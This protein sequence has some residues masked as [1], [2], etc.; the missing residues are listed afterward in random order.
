MNACVSHFSAPLH[1]LCNA[2][3]HFLLSHRQRCQLTV[4]VSTYICRIHPY[5]SPPP[6]FPSRKARYVYPCA[7][8]KHLD[9]SSWLDNFEWAVITH[10]AYGTHTALHVQVYLPRVILC[11]M[12]SP[13]CQVSFAGIFPNSLHISYVLLFL[14]GLPH[15]TNSSHDKYHGKISCLG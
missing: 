7:S 8:K 11:P 9:L 5:S 4:E 13:N 15:E 3:I 1:H 12:H 14:V 6:Y 2:D 10:K